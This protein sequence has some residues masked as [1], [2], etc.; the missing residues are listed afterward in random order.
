MGKTLAITLVFLSTTAG[1]AASPGLSGEQIRLR[2]SGNTLV[3]TEDGLPY[4]QYFI[5]DGTILVQDKEGEYSGHWF[6]RGNQLCVAY[7]DDNGYIPE[8]H[9]C[10]RV[11]LRQNQIIASAIDDDDPLTLEP[12]NPRQLTAQGTGG[13]D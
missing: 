2:V 3:G 10:S 4:F 13:G 11:I 1:L 6:I 12:G 8:T 9:K 5:D 7:E